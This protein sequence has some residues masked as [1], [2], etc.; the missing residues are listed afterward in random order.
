MI[1]KNFFSLA[2][3]LRMWYGGVGGLAGNQFCNMTVR[4]LDG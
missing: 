2:H 1:A 4:G 3:S